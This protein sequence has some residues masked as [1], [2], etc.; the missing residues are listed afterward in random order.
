MKLKVH[1]L[2]SSLQDEFLGM[3]LEEEGNQFIC[4]L[5]KYK[6][7]NVK[8]YSAIFAQSISEEDCILSL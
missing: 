8:L 2:T 4:K 6:T 5:S 3:R 7:I 1:S